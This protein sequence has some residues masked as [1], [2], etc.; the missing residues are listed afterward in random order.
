MVNQ[1]S[2]FQALILLTIC[3][4]A[5]SG[6]GTDP[7]DNGN[8][9][10]P[11]PVKDVTPATEEAAPFEETAK[12]DDGIWTQDFEAA[13]K[14]AAD[15]GKDLLIDFTGSDWCGWCIKLDNEVFAKQEF[16]DE[17]PKHFVLVKL[18]FPSDKSLITEEVKA[19]NEKLQKEYPVQGFPTIFLATADGKAY[20]QTGYRDGGPV[21]YNEHLAELKTEKVKLTEM[22]KNLKNSTATGVEK[23]KLIDEA[24]SVLPPALAETFYGVNIEEYVNQ[25]IELD[26]NNEAGLKF[27]YQLAQRMGEVQEA[28]MSRD[29]KKALE[30]TDAVINDFKPTGED[31]QDIYFNRSESQFYLE[32]KDGAKKTLEMALE[33]APESE[34]ADTIKGTLARFFPEPTAEEIEAAA[35]AAEAAAEEAAEA[36]AVKA[37]KAAGVAEPENNDAIE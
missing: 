27:Q 16:I 26:A 4:I 13:K 8:T 10:E 37:V 30:L 1:K 25:I 35:K 33:A 21:S 5:V 23:A 2:F 36:E 32:D 15:Q 20:A 17:A 34:M 18:D 14:Q 9:P 11:E 7:E 24:V 3:L 19:Q 6:C 12:A 28:K 29:F 31:L 22:L